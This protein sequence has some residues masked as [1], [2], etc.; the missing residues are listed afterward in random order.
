MLSVLGVTLLAGSFVL[1][2]TPFRRRDD[3]QLPP[4]VLA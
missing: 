3:S 1:A 2:V 4:S